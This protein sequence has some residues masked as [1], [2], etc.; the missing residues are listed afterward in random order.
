MLFLSNS[1]ASSPKVSPAEIVKCTWDGLELSGLLSS[2]LQ[3]A[4]F[5]CGGWWPC[6]V[7]DRTHLAV[8]ASYNK[9]GECH[10]ERSA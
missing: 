3:V 6:R 10:R 1:K 8:K 9:C 7:R 4:A 5:V 2:L